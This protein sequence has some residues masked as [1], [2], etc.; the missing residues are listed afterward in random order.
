MRRG[1]SESGG[2][3][4]RGGIDPARKPGRHGLR[5]S[6]ATTRRRGPGR[7]ARREGPSLGLDG[8]VRGRPGL[9]QDPGSGKDGDWT[10]EDGEGPRKASTEFLAD[11]QL[12]CCP[13]AA[14][15]G[16]PAA[17]PTMPH[18]K[19]G[20]ASDRP[21]LARAAGVPIGEGNGDGG[22]ETGTRRAAAPCKGVGLQWVQLPPGN[23]V[24][25][26]GSYRSGGGGNE[27]VGAFETH[28]SLR[29]CS[30]QAGRNASER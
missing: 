20:E 5:G 28:V 22:K 2:D 26:A 21:P 18:L 4:S 6:L 17:G 14:A 8:P 29:R 19:G 7:L 10:K 27:T 24:A 11:P 25:P 16:P 30:E 13:A 23:W 9:G 15:A 12:A 1:W 3:R